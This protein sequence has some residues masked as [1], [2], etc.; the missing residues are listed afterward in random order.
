MGLEG[1]SSGYWTLFDTQWSGLVSRYGS[2]PSPSAPLHVDKRTSGCSIGSVKQG[3]YWNAIYTPDDYRGF[4]FLPQRNLRFSELRKRANIREVKTNSSLSIFAAM[5]VGS[6]AVRVFGFDFTALVLAYG[7]VLPLLWPFRVKSAEFAREL[8]AKGQ[9]HYVRSYALPIGLGI[10]IWGLATD[11][12]RAHLTRES[13]AASALISA[14]FILAV[15][16]LGWKQLC[17]E[18]ASR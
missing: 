16:T 5:L 1:V 18:G 11:L 15:A 9:S 3:S 13:V 17:K 8:S 7:A 4:V 14:L 6:A 12:L 10:L 2:I